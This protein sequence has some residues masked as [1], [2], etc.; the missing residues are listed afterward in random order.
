MHIYLIKLI[1]RKKDNK[2]KIQISGYLQGA[3]GGVG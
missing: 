1:K 3:M 2:H